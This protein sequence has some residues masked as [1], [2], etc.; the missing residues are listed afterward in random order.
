MS[1]YR[2]SLVV[3][4]TPADVY[5]A[6]VTPAGLRGW[7]TQDCDVA[8]AVG[9]TIHFRFGNTHKHMRIE[10]LLRDQEVRWACTG[11]HIAVERLT[12][13]D[14]WVGTEILFRLTAVGE[15]RTRVDFEHIGLVPAFECY[16]L[17][18]DG[19]RYFL[20]SLQQFVETG[21]G[22]PYRT[23]GDAPCRHEAQ[24]ETRSHA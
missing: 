9:G 7:W 15:T 4:G 17:C 14:E 13:N 3:A 20:A 10:R 21:E 22:T 18:T 6:L 11:A 2:K 12:Q 16:D 1:H 19:W 23:A 8:T 5:A 24:R